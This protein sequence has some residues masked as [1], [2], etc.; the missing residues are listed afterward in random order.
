MSNT[1]L[2]VKWRSLDSTKFWFTLFNAKK[3]W[4]NPLLLTHLNW[5]FCTVHNALVK[6]DLLSYFVKNLE[7]FVSQMLSF[8]WCRVNLDFAWNLNLVRNDIVNFNKYFSRKIN[9]A[10]HNRLVTAKEFS[11]EFQLN[12]QIFYLKIFRLFE[13]IYYWWLQLIVNESEI[14][15]WFFPL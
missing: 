14:F 1:N 7:Y 8:F 13:N 5:T 6:L 4:E 3:K 15:L 2:W 9:L 11:Y 10:V 12:V